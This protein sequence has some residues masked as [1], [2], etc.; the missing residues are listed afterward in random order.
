MT[1]NKTPATNIKGEFIR[2]GKNTTI[3][4]SFCSSTF[5]LFQCQLFVIGLKMIL[6]LNIQQK[7]TVIIYMLHQLVL[8]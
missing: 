3:C 7:Q 6:Q 2:T 4:D 1:D 5:V 8:E